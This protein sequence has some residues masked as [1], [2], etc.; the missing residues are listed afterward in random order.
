MPFRL[1][2]NVDDAGLPATVRKLVE[3]YTLPEDFDYVRDVQSPALQ[4]YYAVLQ[5]LALNQAQPEWEAHKD[6][7]MRPDS[8]LF[9]GQ[10]E[11][12]LQRFKELVGIDDTQQHAAPK[13][14]CLYFL[15]S[16]FTKSHLIL[17]PNCAE[18]GCAW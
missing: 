2:A 4:Q 5:A 7:N 1:F 17:Y 6:D 13:V 11:A 8:A 14:S 15:S 9:E 12:V 18:A 10:T 3:S 16:R